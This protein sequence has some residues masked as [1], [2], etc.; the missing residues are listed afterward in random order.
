[1]PISEVDSAFVESGGQK[2]SLSSIFKVSASS[3]N[4]TYLVLNGLDRAEYTAGASGAT[5]SLAGNGASD[6][7]TGIGND[8]RG[9][10]MVFTYQ[11]SSGR[12]FNSTYGYFDQMTYT[13]STSNGDVTNLSLY[14]TNSLG[15]ANAAANNAYELAQNDS[16][17]Y[18]GSATVATEAGFTGSVPTQATPDSICTIADSFVGKAWNQN[19]CWVLASTI[20]ADAGAS[21]PVESAMI[22]VGGQANGEWIVA[23]DGSKQSGNWQSLVKAGEI[24]VIGTGSSG[25][26]TT[27][28]SGSGSTA[29][30]VDNIKYV[31]GSGA[32]LN[33]A[34]DGSA[35]DVKVSAAHAASQEWSGVLSSDVVIYELDTPVVS[36]RVTGATLALSTKL[37]LASLFSAADPANKAITEYQLYDTSATANFSVNGGVT[38]A[39]SAASALTVTSLS[40]VSLTAGTSSGTDTVEVRAFNGSYWGDWDSLSVSVGGSTT[41]TPSTPPATQPTAPSTPAAPAL[42]ASPAPAPAVPPQLGTLM[43]ATPTVPQIW[44][45]GQNV[46]LTLPANTF[47]DSQGLHISYTAQ[48]VVGTLVTSWLN[49]NPSTDTF[50]GHVP[51]AAFGTAVLEVIAT[52]ANGA[53]ATDMFTVAFGPFATASITLVGTTSHALHGVVSMHG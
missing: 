17:G 16:S 37:A 53:S 18:I 30:L 3:S 21:L 4:P 26:I 1:M 33:P 32:V 44:S 9:V 29:M 47:V 40:S 31:N 5:G 12:Y 34:N 49:F 36:N 15:L 48:E 11:S 50:S 38:S 51:A 14:G 39:H 35:S 27:C 43:L 46:S 10:G 23:F 8:G 41:T 52:D 2:I 20:A 6:A 45:D 28:V 7:F 25:H 42:P 24:V 19:G 22:G 13:A